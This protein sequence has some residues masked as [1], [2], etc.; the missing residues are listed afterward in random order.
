LPFGTQGRV[1]PFQELAHSPLFGN[2]PGL[3][4]LNES[5]PLLE[6]G[7]FARAYAELKDITGVKAFKP[8]GGSPSFRPT[9]ATLDEAL[10]A[11]SVSLELENLPDFAP[12]ATVIPDAVGEYAKRMDVLAASAGFSISLHPYIA[13]ASS[14][15]LGMHTDPYDVLVLHMVGAKD[16]HYCVPGGPVA[17]LVDDGARLSAAE[18][19]D[20]YHESHSCPCVDLQPDVIAQMECT[21]VTLRPGDALYLPKG[22]VHGAAN[23]DKHSPAVH[24]TIGLKNAQMQWRDFVSHSVSRSADADSP[25]LVTAR[26][27]VDGIIA[28]KAR[29]PVEGLAWHR[30]FPLSRLMCADAQGDRASG[31]APFNLTCGDRLAQADVASLHH[32]LTTELDE[33]IGAST[34]G[35][36]DARTILR[37]ATQQDTMQSTLA[38]IGDRVTG[39]SCSAPARLHHPGVRCRVL[40]GF[41]QLRPELPLRRQLWLRYRMRL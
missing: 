17:H 41:V 34:P 6:I 22:I 28:A 8:G 9:A 14:T 30:H 38:A 40:H 1:N 5:H 39:V 37:K 25:A 20:I 31:S 23:R 3:V 4:A 7:D 11:H 36:S 26:D 29:H 15:M 24:V 32:A 2:G 33:A 13:I 18:L 10:A 12:G 35:Y 27:A 21:T 16:W 19:A